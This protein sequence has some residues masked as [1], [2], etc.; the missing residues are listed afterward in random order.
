M[1][2]LALP[3]GNLERNTLRLLEAAGFRVEF[4]GRKYTGR[5]QDPCFAHVALMRPQIMPGLIGGG[6]YDIGIC[7]SD[8]V[9]ESI[10]K[11]R[12]IA[13]FNYNSRQFGNGWRIVLVAGGTD[14][15]SKGGEIP[16]EAEILSE[17]RWITEDYF[18]KIHKFVDVK[19]SLGKTEA[20]IPHDFRFGVCVSVTGET[21][22]ANNLKIV[23]VLRNA[24]PL[25]IASPQAMQDKKKNAMLESVAVALT[26]ALASLR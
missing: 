14:V 12:V 21:L 23:E 2:N 16:D 6:N 18:N 19:E 11:A 7:G 26:E 13:R 5:I 4:M 25:L 3:D 17:Y 9:E 15:V 8:W 22:R 20:H 24:N 1:L 10:T